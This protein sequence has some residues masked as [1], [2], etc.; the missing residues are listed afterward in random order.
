[1]KLAKRIIA[2]A[3]V[4][5]TLGAMMIPGVSAAEA[6][7][8][9]SMS[10][11][12]VELFNAAGIPADKYLQSYND[13]LSTVYET[14]NFDFYKDAEGTPVR[15]NAL[16]AGGRYRGGKFLE[17][18]HN[19]IEKYGGTV[20]A[21]F[22][23]VAP[24]TGDYELSFVYG[25]GYSK[26]N[27]GDEIGAYILAMPETPYDKYNVPAPTAEGILAKASLANPGTSGKVTSEGTA[28]LVEGQE[29]LIIFY[30]ID[31]DA[32]AFADFASFS[33][34]YKKPP[35]DPANNIDLIV[36][37]KSDFNAAGIAADGYLQS[38]NLAP[39]TE[40]YN[41]GTIKWDLYK[42]ADGNLSKSNSTYAARAAGNNKYFQLR[43]N[44]DTE[45]GRFPLS[46]VTP[47]TGEYKL[48]LTFAVNAQGAVRAERAGAFIVE[49]PEV[50]PYT[51]YNI[52][53]VT[54]ANAQAIVDFAP[55][56]K[57][58]EG[59]YIYN[60]GSVITSESTV[61]LDG[62]KDY[63][64]VLFSYSATG[65]ATPAYAD[66][67]G[68]SLT[69]VVPSASI[70]ST[71]YNTL[72]DA[73]EAAVSGDTIKLGMDIFEYEVELPEGVILD[74]N[75]KTLNTAAIAGAVIDSKD[76]AGL[77]AVEK[78]AAIIST[79][80]TQ[81]ALWDNNEQA[82]GYRVF[83]YEQT[84]Y[85]VEAG[86]D[87][88]IGVSKLID[89]YEAE[90]IL[91]GP[92]N[93]DENGEVIKGKGDKRYKDVADD[94][95][96]LYADGTIDWRYEYT[97]Q[98]YQMGKGGVCFSWGNKSL[99][100]FGNGYSA[101]RIQAPG[102]GKVSVKVKTSSTGV[103]TNDGGF[104]MY[105]VKA[106]DI[107]AACTDY[108]A[109]YATFLADPATAVADMTTAYAAAIEANEPVVTGVSNGE[110]Y[111][112]TFEF[113]AG[114]E[115]IVIF[116]NN[117]SVK[118]AL[119]M[120]FQEISFTRQEKHGA[121]QTFWSTLKFT[122]PLAYTL[123]NTKESGLKVGFEM[124]WNGIKKSF[125][126]SDEALAAF[127]AD[128]GADATKTYGLYIRISGFEALEEA[129]VLTG[130]AYAT[131]VAGTA[132]AAGS[133]TYNHVV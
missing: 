21:P 127:A 96:A 75:G 111:T 79:A 115:Y 46:I 126:F 23:F 17:I 104:D 93:L 101:I 61:M 20:T 49:A 81:V 24:G 77:I 40:A 110:A 88:V 67:K 71:P 5:C 119:H 28:A 92:E 13:A 39:L 53:S 32:K 56:A 29:Y 89:L 36:D 69:E 42:D 86:R 33:L 6:E 97:S 45:I 50:T 1:M 9:A 108:A 102:E 132:Y 133:M 106:S 16:Y 4:L 122:N 103:E 47:G 54:A 94:L 98:Q 26:D 8:P 131:T 25:K 125:E 37:F 112:G 41:A 105:I 78:E 11:N 114:A 82:P 12:F 59:N 85:G 118:G 124:D 116:N 117:G 87:D 48:S 76:G 31:A 10:V 100:H 107:E 99:R 3:V 130:K 66:F 30:V 2:L 120:N 83:N 51:R 72:N 19:D 62:D 113:E 52:P 60:T 55:N 34:D 27:G 43:T 121:T 68:F 65:K 90:R 7:I 57:D 22:K 73:L 128:Q 95:A 80:A 84:N 123:V 63:I 91:V 129:G 74:L 58:G 18:T 35:F 70:G 15:P 38:G 44:S 109:S 64:L 14:Y